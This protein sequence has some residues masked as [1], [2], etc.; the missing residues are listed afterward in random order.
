MYPL[1]KFKIS[2]IKESGKKEYLFEEELDQSQKL[3]RNER[4]PKLAD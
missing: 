2:K 4:F 1:N 3:G